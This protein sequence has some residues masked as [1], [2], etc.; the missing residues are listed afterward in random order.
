MGEEKVSE[1][2][3]FMQ[4]MLA[5]GKEELGRYKEGFKSDAGRAEQLIQNAREQIKVNYEKEMGRIARE[6]EEK[7][8]ELNERRALF[9]QK[10]KE[11][12]ESQ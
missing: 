7:T 1:F 8:R 5:K 4:R 6:Y 11:L 3:E 10:L 2:A 9:E 12:E